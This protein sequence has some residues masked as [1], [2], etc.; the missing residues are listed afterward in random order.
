MTAPVIDQSNIKLKPVQNS[1]LRFLYNHLKDRDSK[2]NIS[3]RKIPTLKEHVKF[4]LSKPYSRWYIIMLKNRKI[5]TVYLTKLNEIGFHLQK[6]FKSN[7]IKET[8]IE[9]LIDKTEKQKYF[10]NL[11]PRN[12]TAIRFFKTQGFKLIQY[13]YELEK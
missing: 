6:N 8:V 4:V 5:G 13:T 1:D 2:A 12:K 9:I 7:K 10:V 3:H 11:S